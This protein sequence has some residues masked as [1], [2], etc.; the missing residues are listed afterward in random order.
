VDVLV[1]AVADHEG[2]ALAHGHQAH[3]RRP[4]QP[5]WLVETGEFADV[6]DLQSG[7][8]LAQLT[9]PGEE[10]VEQLV[11]P[12]GGHDRRAIGDDGGALALERDAAEAGDQ[13]FPAFIAPQRDLEAEPAALATAWGSSNATS[14]W[15]RVGAA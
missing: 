5:S 12:G 2:L 10:P 14:I 7:A 1:A 11:A 3:P 4:F 15:S 9:P 13:R 8:S 6:V